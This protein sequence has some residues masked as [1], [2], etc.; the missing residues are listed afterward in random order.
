[1]TDPTPGPI[2]V[3]GLNDI[4][5][6]AQEMA[7][8]TNQ[9][10]ERLAGLTGR[11]ESADGL[12]RVACTGDDPVHEVV[13]DPRALRYAAADLAETLQTLIRQARVDLN[14]QVSDVF[15]EQTGDAGP[16]AL[17]QNPELAQAKMAQLREMVDSASQ[18]SSALMERMRRQF[19]A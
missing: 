15:R 19:G 6:K 7:A 14:Q 10:Q 2:D 13:I 9:L 18:G 1:M 12:V 5:R 3:G 17:L 4:L 16:M 11:A 8:Q